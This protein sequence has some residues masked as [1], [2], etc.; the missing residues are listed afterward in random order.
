MRYAVTNWDN[1]CLKYRM[2]IMNGC[3]SL[4][5]TEW[6]N[7]MEDSESSLAKDILGESVYEDELVY[8][9]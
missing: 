6:S 7:F 9:R 3:L 5:H 4:S 8:N 2:K 1:V